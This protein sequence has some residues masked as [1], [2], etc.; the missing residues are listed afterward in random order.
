MEHYEKTLSSKLIF[1]GKIIRVAVDAVELENGNISEREVVHHSGGACMAAITDDNKVLMTRQYR[2]AMQEELLE[3]PAGKLEKG[4]D[5]FEAA[6][7]ELAEEAGVTAEEFIDLGKFYPTCGYCSE[8]IHLYGAKTLTTVGQHLDTDEFLNV[9][10][11][12]LAELVKKCL[13]GEIRDGKTVVGILRLQS[14]I[15]QGLF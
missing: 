10:S 4:E 12:P 6:K 13:S 1:D 9:S 15:E 7:R 3:L 8:V 11:V 5:P 2:Y 14:Y